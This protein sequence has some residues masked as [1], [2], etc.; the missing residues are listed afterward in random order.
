MPSPQHGRDG[1]ERLDEKLLLPR[2]DIRVC[3]C[4]TTRPVVQMNYV[5]RRAQSF[6]ERESSVTEESESLV[7]IMKAVN[8]IARE[9]LRRVN[10]K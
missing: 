2:I 10:Q 6:E 5:W 4:E 9:I 7:V 3:G 8:R 1:I